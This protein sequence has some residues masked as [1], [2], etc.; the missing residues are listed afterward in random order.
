MSALSQALASRYRT[1]KSR[2]ISEDTYFRALKKLADLGNPHRPGSAERVFADMDRA[3]ILRH[4]I[5][6]L[7][8]RVRELEAVK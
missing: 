2:K 5:A 7:E 1:L 6:L 8:K 3:L 4:R